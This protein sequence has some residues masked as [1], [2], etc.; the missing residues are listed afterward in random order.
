MLSTKGATEHER[1]S[2]S[3]PPSKYGEKGGGGQGHALVVGARTV[4]RVPELPT[5]S[6]RLHIRARDALARTTGAL[7]PSHVARLRQD[8]SSGDMSNAVVALCDTAKSRPGSRVDPVYSQEA[9]EREGSI[10]NVYADACAAPLHARNVPLAARR[11]PRAP[12]R[13]STAEK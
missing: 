3:S 6:L 12:K 10:S 13:F 4:R 1:A 11:S 8:A 9:T 7:L 2:A 5:R